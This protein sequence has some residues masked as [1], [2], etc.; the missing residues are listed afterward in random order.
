MGKLGIVLKK[1]ITVNCLASF[2][3]Y[4]EVDYCEPVQRLALDCEEKG[5]FVIMVP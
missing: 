5:Y 3:S 1:G 2:I 4:S